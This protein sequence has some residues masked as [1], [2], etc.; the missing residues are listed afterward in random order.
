MDII[1]TGGTGFIGRRLCRALVQEGHRLTVFSRK[2]EQVS[3]ICGDQCAGI[4]SLKDLG[5]EQHF[6]A[7]INLSGESIAAER[8]TGRRKQILRD[9]RIGVSAEI[10]EWIR[11]SPSNPPVLI[12]GSAVGYYGNRG[13]TEL[14]ETSGALDDFGHRLCSDWESE[15]RKAENYGVRVCIIRIGLVVGPKGGFLKPMLLPFK[16]GLGGPIAKGQQWMSWIHLKDLIEIIKRLINDPELSGVFNATS[17]RPVTNRDF[18]ATLAKVLC[19]PAFIPVPGVLLKL[20]LGEMSTLLTG[21]QKVLPARL[22][23]AGFHYQFTDLKDALRET[24]VH[25]NN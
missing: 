16:M 12:S 17:P 13:D 11:R 23:E 24:L 8:W 25:P 20:L 22:L 18:T 19:R 5:N 21:G 1:I 2:P 15:A 6:D 14:V 9:S 7:I 4:R 10:L 3:T